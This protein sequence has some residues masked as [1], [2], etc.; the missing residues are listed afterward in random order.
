MDVAF[1][2]PK[3]NGSMFFAR[4]FD[5]ASGKRPL[6][7][8][9]PARAVAEED[10]FGGRALTLTGATEDLAAFDAAALEWMLTKGR[11]EWFDTALDDERIRGMFRP[12]R[13]E[14]GSAVAASAQGLLRVVLELQG[15]YV[16]K[17]EFGLTWTVRSA[18]D[19]EPEEP[20]DVRAEVEATWEADVERYER[21]V[22]E[23]VAAWAQLIEE[24]RAACARVRQLFEAARCSEGAEWDAHFERL[25]EALRQE[26]PS[27]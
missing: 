5:P 26:A 23:R 2:P 17:K 16:R 20:G 4:A 9:A 25:A 1:H 21:E 11:T 27:L 13:Q 10:V 14:D 18:E 7:E 22:E 24:A 12:A 3:C 8:L 15:M 6:C 19:L